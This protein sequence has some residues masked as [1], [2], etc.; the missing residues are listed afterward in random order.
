VHYVDQFQRFIHGHLD[1]ASF[2]CQNIKARGVW[3]NKAV[4]FMATKKQK[5]SQFGEEVSQ[6]PF[7]DIPP[8]NSA[9]SS[10]A[11]FIKVLCLPVGLADSHILAWSPLRITFNIKL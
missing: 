4:Y 3:R 2:V 5:K 1:L 6:Y 11:Q 10:M 9:S 8:N 7:K